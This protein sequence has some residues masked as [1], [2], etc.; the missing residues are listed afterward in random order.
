MNEQQKEI[1][2]L[3]AENAR[4]REA[5]RRIAA[6]DAPDAQAMIAQARAA[7]DAKGAR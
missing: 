4:L 2:A 5:L 1:A 3:R 7:L 6:Y